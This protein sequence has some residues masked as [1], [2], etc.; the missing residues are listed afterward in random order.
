MNNSIDLGHDAGSPAQMPLRGWWQ[1]LKRTY[2]ESGKDNLGLIASGVAFYGFLAMVPLLGAMVLTYGLVVDPADLNQ[3][4]RAITGMVPSEA[5]KL[6]DE[7]LTNVVTTAAGKKGLGLALALLLALYGAMKGAGAIIIALNIAY[8][9]KETR[10]FIKLNLV[11]AAITLAAV[12]LAVAGLLSVSVTGFLEDFA[13]RISPAVAIAT[14]V[15]AWIVTA[16]LASGAVAALYRYAP[17]RREPRWTWLTPGSLAATVGFVATT[18]GFGFYAAH[19]GN[20]N[21]TYGSLGAIVVLLLWLYLSAYVLLLGAELNAELEHQ[22]AR[23]TTR[24]PEKPMGSRRAKM[25]DEVA[26]D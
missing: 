3:H 19:F 17:N 26:A 5:A 13:G 6:I 16:L 14:K 4:M 24:G 15:T 11:Q 1:I 25:A 2:A 20:Y 22:T 23:D 7:Q 9:E 8:E 21:A 10:G 18:L 12:L